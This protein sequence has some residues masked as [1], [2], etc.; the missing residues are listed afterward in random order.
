LDTANFFIAKQEKKRRDTSSVLIGLWLS[1]QLNL[2]LS[3]EDQ[4][5]SGSTGFQLLHFFSL[6]GM[7]SPATW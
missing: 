6:T 3:T 7:D 4:P 2:F 1:V 5:V